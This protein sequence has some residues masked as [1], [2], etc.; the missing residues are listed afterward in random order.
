MSG[1]RIRTLAKNINQ[2]RILIIAA[3][4][5]LLA[6]FSVVSFL[7]NFDHLQRL[8]EESQGTSGLELTPS[9]GKMM[10]SGS[11]ASPASVDPAEVAA[12]LAPLNR[13]RAMV[14]LAPV[15]ADPQLSRGDFLHSHYLAVNYAAELP[16]L[17]LGA[18]AHTEDPAKPAFTADGATAARASDI[19]WLW[20]PHGGPKPSWAISNWIQVPFH[21][22][23][24]INPYLHR[25][26]YGTDCQGAV[27][28]AALNTGTDV[29]RPLMLRAPWARP[30][31]FPPDG[32]VMHMGEFSEEWPNPLTSCPGYLSPAGL[33]I[34][35]ELGHMLVPAFS[36]CS[37]KRVDN[38]TALEACAFNASTYVNPDPAA[39]AAARA[40]LED[41]GAIIIVPR[42]PLSPGHY[43]VSVTAGGRYS[44]S[45][46]VVARGRE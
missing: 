32:S 35:L 39:Q 22:M 30:L 3:L 43:A 14:G 46:S 5:L 7:L 25:V 15:A 13:Y 44:W 24:M 29:D 26:G 45:F 11:E 12:W 36:D 19:D 23:Q 31:A 21:R 33:P 40:I 10:A 18:D 16:D 2:R 37:V 38:G 27:C 4:L 28:F 1:E 8:A 9:E 6:G 34:T 41:F 42:R 17:S 20:D